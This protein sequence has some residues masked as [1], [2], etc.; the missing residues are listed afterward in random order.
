MQAIRQYATAYLAWLDDSGPEPKAF[1]F[2]FQSFRKPPE[3][4]RVTGPD[5]QPL[6]GIRRC[7]C[8]LVLIYL[9]DPSTVPDH[10]ASEPHR[11]AMVEK[12]LWNEIDHPPIL[13]EAFAGPSVTIT[14][15]TVTPKAEV[16]SFEAPARVP[17]PPDPLM[18]PAIDVYTDGSGTRANL[19]CGAGVVMMEGER[20][21]AEI[22]RHLGNGTNN[23][24]ELSGVGAALRLLGE[25]PWRG[26]RCV[27]RSDSSY[28]I[29]MLSSDR[30]PTPEQTNGRL[31]SVIRRMLPDSQRLS[32]ELVKGHSGIPGNERADKLASM[33]RKLYL[34]LPGETVQETAVAG[35]WVMDLG[36]EVVAETTRHGGARPAAELAAARLAVMM[37]DAP[38]WRKRRVVLRS[39][40]EHALAV[41]AS[42][43]DEDDRFLEALARFLL[44]GRMEK[45]P[46]EE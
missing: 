11:Q 10:E 25:S 14:P 40:S 38:H 1:D 24:A 13:N 32:F 26:R 2:S 7:E 45:L 20:I 17:E 31:I 19:V 36:E 29:D 22:S 23:R 3:H 39:D 21:V 15:P 18:L 43:Q 16:A 9:D 8:G 12:G 46:N 34:D 30:E 28:T 44:R 5:G 41:L 4:H 37:L 35:A 6:Q 42:K 33:G 27:I